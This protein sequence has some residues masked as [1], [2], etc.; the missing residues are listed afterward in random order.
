MKKFQNGF[1]V[2]EIVLVIVIVGLVGVVSWFVYDRQATTENTEYSQK[3]V[4]Q[5]IEVTDSSS[6][7][8]FKHPDNW[9]IE[10][11]EWTNC[12]DGPEVVEPDWT[13][14][15]K[16]ITLHPAIDENVVV[17]VFMEN[18]GGFWESYDAL[19][20][21]VDEDYFA[22]IIFEG[23]REDGH[24]AL[25]SRVDYLGPPDAKVESF[26]DHRYYFDNGNAVLKVEFREKYHHD[27]DDDAE[28]P[29]IDNTK[30]LSDFE[31]IA[32]SIKFLK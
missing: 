17:T 19:K 3:E 8:S 30:Y 25:F 6:T 13:K 31:S 5:N 12:C 1:S 28:R 10:P 22:T 9:E 16:P 27:W 23:R 26:T 14:V 4:V 2:V 32:N 21:S 20:A 24:E 29:D 11:Y 18:Y 7:F 15:S